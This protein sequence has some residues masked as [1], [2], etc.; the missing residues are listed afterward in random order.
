L[1][2]IAIDEEPEESGVLSVHSKSFAAKRRV[3]FTLEHPYSLSEVS[4]KLNGKIYTPDW[5]KDATS[6][7]SYELIRS[8]TAVIV[9][10]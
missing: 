8:A 7:G 3:V 9:V 10:P 2:K 6:I 1:Y 4:F 5:T